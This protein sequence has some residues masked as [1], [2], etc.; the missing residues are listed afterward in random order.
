MLLNPN[1]GSGRVQLWTGG[2]RDFGVVVSMDGSV[3]DSRATANSSPPPQPNLVIEAAHQPAEKSSAPSSASASP[4][5]RAE[6]PPA[7]AFAQIADRPA[8]LVDDVTRHHRP[9]KQD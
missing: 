4:S 1:N 5:F 7:S 8:L 6:N 2:E 9:K 3:L